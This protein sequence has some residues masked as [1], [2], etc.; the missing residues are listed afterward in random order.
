MATTRDLPIPNLFLAALPQEDYD[1]LLPHLEPVKLSSRQILFEAGRPID[2]CYFTDGGMSSLLIPLEDGAM[3]EAGVVG[4]EGFAGLSAVLG[5][6]TS[7][8]TGM[9]QLPG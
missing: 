5:A 3:I 7:A 2:Y 6:E 4:K 8:H 9:T 1:R